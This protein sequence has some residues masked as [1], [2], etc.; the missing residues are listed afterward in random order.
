MTDPLIITIFIALVLAG[1]FAICMIAIQVLI[2]VLIENF[3]FNFQNKF[4]KFKKF[5]F[6]SFEVLLN[7][8]AKIKK[9]KI[10]KI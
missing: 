7:P 3:D 4:N 5:I 1:F 2:F 6:K 9:I 10:D 8:V